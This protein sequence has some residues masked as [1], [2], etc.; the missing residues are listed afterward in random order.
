MSHYCPP[1]RYCRC[2][3]FTWSISIVPNLILIPPKPSIPHYPVSITVQSIGFYYFNC[4]SHG[5][6]MQLPYLFLF[7]FPFSIQSYFYFLFRWDQQSD[8]DD[9]SDSDSDSD[10]L[11][12]PFAFL[13]FPSLFQSSPVQTTSFYL[14]LMYLFPAF[15][16]ALAL[17]LFTLIHSP[18][19]RL[20]AFLFLSLAHLIASLAFLFFRLLLVLLM[21]SLLCW[22]LAHFSA[23]IQS[24]F[25]HGI[26]ITYKQHIY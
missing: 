17:T 24:R 1:C 3:R 20:L 23:P 26:N 14:V 2:S 18:F 19:A 15:A 7:L 4:C 11:F 16:F 21:R 9:D 10:D 13:R 5:F 12:P 6:T 8:S 22:L 25:Y